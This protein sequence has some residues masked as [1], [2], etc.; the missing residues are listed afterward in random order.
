MYPDAL[1]LSRD[2]GHIRVYDE[3]PYGSYQT[4]SEFIFRVSRSD[5][6]MHPK[7]RVIGLYKGSSSKVY[8]LG[9][10]G[11]STQAINDQF[12]DQSIVVV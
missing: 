4:S 3:Y 5:N 11:S 7:Q 10:F 9:A 12:K 1:V 6:R 8:Q 2:T